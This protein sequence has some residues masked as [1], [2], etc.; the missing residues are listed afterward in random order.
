VTVFRRF[1]QP[2]LIG[3]V[4]STGIGVG[5]P[6][7]VK[8]ASQAAQPPTP[9]IQVQ[10]AGGLYIH[11]TVKTFL[12]FKRERAVLQR[13]DF[14]CGAAALATLMQCY[15]KLNVSEASIVLY[16][17][18]MRGAE[19]AVKRYKEKKGFS[20]LDL[21]MAA[22]S[23]G[24]R[25]PAY[26]DMTLADLVAL[27]E[28]AIVPIR[29]RSFDHFVLFRGVEGDRVYL[30]DPVAGNVTMKAAN[31]VA[32]WHGGIGMVFESTKGLKP[33]GWK[34]NKSTQGFY[35]PQDMVRT[36]L[37]PSGLGFQPKLAGEF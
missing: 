2:I 18:H 8:A 11:K 14:S 15:Y 3:L 27:N 23:A 22:Q 29:T 16:I 34:P 7:G 20:L 37:T 28:P 32:I 5:L 12:D 24:F 1:Q 25:C 19:Q 13:Y 10:T 9:T 33:V 6:I 36:L 35:V 21:K 31:F 4:L 26:R 30:A 17:I